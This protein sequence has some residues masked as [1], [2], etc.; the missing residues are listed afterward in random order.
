MKLISPQLPTTLSGAI[1][2]LIGLVIL[3]VVVSIPVYFA[4][5]AITGGK[6]DFGDAMGA[7]LGGAVGYFLVLLGVSYFLEAVIG[8]SAGVLALLLA[9]VVWLAA[10]K[11]AFRTSWIKAVGIVVLAWVILVVID[12]ALI[13]VAGVTFP[14][15]FPFA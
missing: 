10:Y 9:L 14:N 4:G 8:S 13:H 12:F 5:K 6:S 3:W 11:V 7:T 1:I 2:Y 15:F